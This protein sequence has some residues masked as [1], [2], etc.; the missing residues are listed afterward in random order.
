MRYGYALA[1]QLDTSAI[2]LSGLGPAATDIDPTDGIR[3]DRSVIY[4]FW[5]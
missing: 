5:R 3:S 2:T 1:I 4:G